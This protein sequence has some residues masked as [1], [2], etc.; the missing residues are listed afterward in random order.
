MHPEYE[1]YSF[2]LSDMSSKEKR[3]LFHQEGERNIRKADELVPSRHSQFEYK[4]DKQ[5]QAS[6]HPRRWMTAFSREYL[7][8]IPTSSIFTS[9]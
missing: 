6:F 9:V 7:N 3:S 1:K 4:D 5:K 8:P 2:I